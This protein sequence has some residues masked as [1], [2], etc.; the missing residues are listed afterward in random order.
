ML[1]SDFTFVFYTRSSSVGLEFSVCL[2]STFS[3]FYYI[4]LV[5]R[6]VEISLVL[7]TNNAAASRGVSNVPSSSIASG[8]DSAYGPLLCCF[9][10][11]LLYFRLVL[12]RLDLSSLCV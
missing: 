3:H 9:Q 12:L 6:L 8:G 5:F 7:D 10:T 11:S 4:L 1:F 2:E